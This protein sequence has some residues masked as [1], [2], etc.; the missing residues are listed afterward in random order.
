MVAQHS[1]V[2]SRDVEVRTPM[3]SV[4]LQDD[5]QENPISLGVEIL[6]GDA[7]GESDR[8]GSLLIARLW[9]GTG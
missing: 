7:R 5:K 3:G 6:E 8:Q 1:H 4:S 2:D 9:A